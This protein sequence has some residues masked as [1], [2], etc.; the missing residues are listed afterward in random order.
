M[1]ANGKNLGEKWRHIEKT[2]IRAVKMIKPEGKKDR[3]L[4]WFDEKWKK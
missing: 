1:E 3:K 4:K 2:V